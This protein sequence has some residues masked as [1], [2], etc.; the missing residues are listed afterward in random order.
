MPTSDS[1]FES[2][3]QLVFEWGLGQLGLAINPAS[4]QVV[5]ITPITGDPDGRNTKLNVTI[6]GSPTEHALH[7]YRL[8]ATQYAKLGEDT[9]FE[10]QEETSLSEL[11]PR[12]AE[13][14]PF[15]LNV[16]DFIDFPIDRSGGYPV[17]IIVTPKAESL[18]FNGSLSVFLTPLLTD[19]IPAARSIL[20]FEGTNGSM[21]F[22]D[23]M[24]LTWVPITTDATITTYLRVEGR[25]SG[26]FLNAGQIR[27][28]D[29]A[30]FDWRSP[31]TLQFHLHSAGATMDR[32]LFQAGSVDGVHGGMKVRIANGYLRMSLTTESGVVEIN[33]P[34]LF[35][36]L[37]GSTFD[38]VEFNYDGTDC[39]L[40]VEGSLKTQQPV[41]NILAPD[42]LGSYT[43]IGTDAAGSFS[44]WFAVIDRFVLSGTCLHTADFTPPSHK[45]IPLE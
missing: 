36:A 44:G 20:R 4:V 7:Y 21:D 2:L 5:S 27:T 6:D 35:P 14:S 11:F 32:V 34:N 42:A 31:W 40:F 45:P 37:G 41:S 33:D 1:N 29:L 9:S 15:P 8:D 43:Y 25:G 17:E 22:V 28:A 16:S 26:Q 10:D 3:T 23:D 24:G 19:P 38:H 18:K 39:R 13:R 30:S 12:I